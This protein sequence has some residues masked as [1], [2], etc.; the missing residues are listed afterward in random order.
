MRLF[1]KLRLYEAIDPLLVEAAK[2]DAG[3][4]QPALETLAKIADPDKRDLSR[5]LNLLANVPQ[6]KQ[7]DAVQRAI[8]I[9]CNKSTGIQDRSAL[10]LPYLP[11][12]K[13]DDFQVKLLP[14]LGRLGRRERGLR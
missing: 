3:D 11:A 8:L 2:P 9:V 1:A 10:V 12:E 14:L 4:Y 5:L 6:G 7:S 13:S